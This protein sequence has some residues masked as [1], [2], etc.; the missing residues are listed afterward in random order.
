[1]HFA[2]IRQIGRTRSRINVAS[3]IRN[4]G[5]VYVRIHTL[6]FLGNKSAITWSIFRPTKRSSLNI[7]KLK[8]A[9]HRDEWRLCV[10]RKLKL[11]LQTYARVYHFTVYHAVMNGFVTFLYIDIFNCSNVKQFEKKTKIKWLKRHFIGKYNAVSFFTA[12]R[13]LAL[14]SECIRL[15]ERNEKLLLHVMAFM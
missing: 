15:H 4:I 2:E 3:S 1:M 6:H 13:F 11:L 10:F 14:F 9:F 8:F 12:S 5:R 7:L